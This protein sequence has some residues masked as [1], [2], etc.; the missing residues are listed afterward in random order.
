MGEVD[1]VCELFDDGGDRMCAVGRYA[2]FDNTKLCSCMLVVAGVIHK[3]CEWLMPT[4][5]G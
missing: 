2:G 4:K 5:Q 3:R 1:G